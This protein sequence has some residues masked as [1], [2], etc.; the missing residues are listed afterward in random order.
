MLRLCSQHRQAHELTTSARAQRACSSAQATQVG[1]WWVQLYSSL[2]CQSGVWG[3]GGIKRALCLWTL[4][5]QNDGS[6]D[7]DVAH[8]KPTALRHTRLHSQHCLYPW[9]GWLPRR[10]ICLASNSDSG[11]NSAFSNIPTIVPALYL[12]AV[13]VLASSKPDRPPQMW[14]IFTWVIEIV[15]TSHVRVPWA[16]MTVRIANSDLRKVM[17]G[18]ETML[19]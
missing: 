9:R 16:S 8:D 3:W 19:G 4:N 14:L 7:I 11:Q 17:S 18:S 12:P 15:S 2:D 13:E 10:Y 6:L 1:E 5:A